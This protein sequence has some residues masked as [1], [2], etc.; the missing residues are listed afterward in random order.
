MHVGYLLLYV[1]VRATIVQILCLN[2]ERDMAQNVSKTRCSA[3][4]WNQLVFTIIDACH[5]NQ[6]FNSYESPICVN[7]QCI[8]RQRNTSLSGQHVFKTILYVMTR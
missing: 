6:L 5:R 1:D 8:N 3:G 7:R 4:R 2:S